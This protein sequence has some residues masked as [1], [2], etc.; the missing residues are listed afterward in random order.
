MHRFPF[1]FIASL[2]A[3]AAC[4]ADPPEAPRKSDAELLYEKLLEAHVRDP[5]KAYEAYLKALEA[6]NQKIVK[7]LEDAIKDLD[8]PRKG[9]LSITERAKMIGELTAKIED[10]KQGAVGETVMERASGDL[11]GDKP[12]LMRLIVGRWLTS[13]SPGIVDLQVNGNAIYTHGATVLNGKVKIAANTV[14]L[15]WDS[16]TIVTFSKFSGDVM[17]GTSNKLGEVTYTRMKP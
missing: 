9:S 4:A 7:G 17:L 16:G 2:A 8:N 11:L 10:V 12:N 15:T 3:C 14:V 5:A 1:A 13:T 6:A